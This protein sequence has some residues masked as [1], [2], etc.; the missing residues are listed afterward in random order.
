MEALRKKNVLLT[1]GRFQ[2]F[3]SLHNDM[4]GGAAQQFFCEP[5][6]DSDDPDECVYREDTL[7]LLEMT[8]RD[9]MEARPRPALGTAR[10]VCSWTPHTQLQPH[11]AQE[12]TRADL[13]RHP[14]ARVDHGRAD[15][16]AGLDSPDA[17]AL[18]CAACRA[19]TCW[20][21]PAMPASTSAPSCSASTRSASWATPCSCAPPAPVSCAAPCALQQACWL[22]S[23]GSMPCANAAADSQLGCSGLL[24]APCATVPQRSASTRSAPGSGLLRVRFSRLACSA[25]MVQHAR[26]VR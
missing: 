1:R 20:T 24:C 8:T 21:G 11:P 7:V 19:A 22:H 2:P 12:V 10:R 17:W 23:R 26:W 4:L 16:L 15:L 5:A 18:T 25:L 6:T 13:G 14:G 3:T 9:M